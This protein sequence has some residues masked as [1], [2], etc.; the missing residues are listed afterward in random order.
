MKYVDSVLGPDFFHAL[1]ISL[2]QQHVTVDVERLL[3]SAN[4]LSAQLSSLAGQF[5]SNVQG[6]PANVFEAFIN[7]TKQRLSLV[8]QMV[9]E[10]KPAL[11]EF[12]DWV[13]GQ[14][15]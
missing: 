6:G 3:Q 15:L 12:R 14:R 7:D 9:E 1:D 8:I 4:D 13:G 2:A 5:S 11:N 10:E